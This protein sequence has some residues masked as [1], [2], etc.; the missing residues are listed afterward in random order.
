MYS[1]SRRR[2]AFTL[3]E[4][5]VV[6]AIIAILIGLLLPAVQKVREAAARNKCMNNIKQIVLALHN[7]HSAN[8]KFPPGYTGFNSKN[9]F[10][11]QNYKPWAWSVFILPYI[12]QQALYTQL[13]PD[14]NTMT[15]VANTNLQLLQ[16]SIPT[17]QC[18]SDNPPPSFPLND[19]RPFTKLVAGQTVFLSISNYP[20]CFGGAAEWD[21]LF[22]Q[23]DAAYAIATGKVRYIQYKIDDIADGTSNQFA[24]GERCSNLLTG[25]LR[26][27]TPPPPAQWAAVWAGIDG[28]QSDTDAEPKPV[29]EY[30]VFGY[31]A[32]RMQ[33]GFNNGTDSNKK[34]NYRPDQGFSSMHSGGC[35]MGLADGSVRFVNQNI[36]W[37]GGT[38]DYSK[39]GT[40][41]RAG[42]RNDNNPLGNDW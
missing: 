12:E 16:T 3:I 32:V 27:L 30:A 34:N 36:S 7:Y 17:Y 37:V 9:L 1:P 40:W 33:D 4:L 19:N 8:G 24:V 41:E 35:N 23:Q 18:P 38:S 42:C 28:E 6:I 26:T 29:R 31:T 21:G 10:P 5:L 39:V 15:T 20:G 22:N 2:Q 14:V 25:D 13:N 11:K